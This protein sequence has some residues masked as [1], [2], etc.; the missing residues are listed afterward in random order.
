MLKDFNNVWVDDPCTLKSMVQDYFTSLFKGMDVT[1]NQNLHRLPHNCLSSADNTILDKPL[2]NS[3]IWSNMKYIP[4]YKAPG[5]DGIQAI[6]YHKFWDT[7]CNNICDFIKNCFDTRSVPKEMNKTV[8]TLIA[9][10][11]KTENPENVKM[12]RPISL[13]NVMY[14]GIT[15]ILVTR[16]GLF[17]HKIISPFQSSFIPG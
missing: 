9:L 3:E 10:I 4:A 6:F 14:K 13:C 8:K 1:V 12:L 15:K 7:V 5:P 16:L 17:L 2:S 11:P